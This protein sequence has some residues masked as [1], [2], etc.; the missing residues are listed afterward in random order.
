MSATYP[1]YSDFVTTSQLATHAHDSAWVLV[2]CSFD[3]AEP[4]WGRENYLEGHIP[5]AIYA[6]LDE[7]LSAPKTARTGR[8]PLPDVGIMA[9]RLG[10]WGIG[11]GRQVIVYDTASGAFAA[12]LWWMLHYYGYPAA[13][14]LDGGYAKWVEEGRPLVSGQ[15]APHPAAH[16]VPKLHPEMLVSQEDV[17]NIRLDPAW[18]LVDARSAVRYRGEQEP[19]DPVKGHIPG[20]VNRFHGENLKTDGT[21]LPKAELRRQ[22]K[23][24]LGGTPVNQTVVYCGSG[25]TSCFHVAAMYRAGLGMPRLYAGS[26]SEWIR[27]PKNPIEP[28]P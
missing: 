13:A 3:L 27:D 14:I 23:K 5:G 21:L 15:E 7:D 26:W 22:L 1:T 9:Q 11:P 8:H 19:I 18:K 24:L 2:D 28:A 4:A 25:V 10:Q 6:H 16:F 20:S 17:E 12:R